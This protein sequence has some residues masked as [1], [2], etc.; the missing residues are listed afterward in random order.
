MSHYH[1]NAGRLNDGLTYR[2]AR[3]DPILSDLLFSKE[4]LQEGLQKLAD[5]PGVGAIAYSPDVTELF[6]NILERR[7][8]VNDGDD[9]FQMPHYGIYEDDSMAAFYGVDTS[10]RSNIN[11][12]YEEFGDIKD[13]LIRE[14]IHEILPEIEGIKAQMALYEIESWAR[15]GTADEM[16]YVHKD[17]DVTLLRNFDHGWSALDR[18]TATNDKHNT[19]NMYDVQ[20]EYVQQIPHQAWLVDEDQKPQYHQYQQYN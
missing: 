7:Y 5:T 20:P 16:P 2:V 13:R 3:G 8:A 15:H 1:A 17:V 11:T 12:E 10:D 6:N 18:P 4:T 14:T 19:I 9:K